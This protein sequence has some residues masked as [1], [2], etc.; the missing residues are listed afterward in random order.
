M[1]KIYDNMQ[2]VHIAVEALVLSTVVF[3]FNKKNQTLT[4]K[5]VELNQRLAEQESVIQQHEQ[6]IRSIINSINSSSGVI[7]QPSQVLIRKPKAKAKPVAVEKEK[8]VEKEPTISFEPYEGS[9][10]G[11]KTSG[12][13]DDLM[14]INESETSVLNAELEN[15]LRELEDDDYDS[16]GSTSTV[17]DQKKT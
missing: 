7:H 2:L 15:E 13:D 12:D 5:I 9:I 1:P 17:N 8:P 11:S 3:I 6:M 16:D 10:E 14:S 4:N